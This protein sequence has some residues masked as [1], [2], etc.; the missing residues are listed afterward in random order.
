[1]G[2][3]VAV[4]VDDAANVAAFKDFTADA[5]AAPAAAAPAAEPAAAPAAPAAPAAQPAASVPLPAS[6][7]R[8]YWNESK[9]WFRA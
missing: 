6:G 2:T 3:A 8:I 5:P 9:G 1:M 7:G 4:V